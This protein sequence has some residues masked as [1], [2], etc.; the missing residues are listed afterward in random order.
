[1]AASAKA[2]AKKKYLLGGLLVVAT[3]FLVVAPSVN[4]INVLSIQRCESWTG[5]G[6]ARHSCSQAD[7]LAAVL[8]LGSKVDTNS[9]CFGNE[10]R[11]DDTFS[12]M[13][14]GT[15][16]VSA[17]VNLKGVDSAAF[18]WAFVTAGGVTTR[19]NNPDPFV[20]DNGNNIN[21]S[22]NDAGGAIVFG[23]HEDAFGDPLDVTVS[24]IST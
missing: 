12:S 15:G 24:G 7:P 19:I 13:L 10:A 8:T 21:F 4:A 23:A 14:P 2:M 6:P 9:F 1:M 3:A 22:G 18:D 16:T 11:G 5:A 17:R 20:C